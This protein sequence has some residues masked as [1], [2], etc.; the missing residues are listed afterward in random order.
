MGNEGPHLV[1]DWTLDHAFEETLQALDDA[2]LE[3]ADDDVREHLRRRDEARDLAMMVDRE[4][5][6]GARL[7]TRMQHQPSR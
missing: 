1:L 2:N 3:V 5:E 6:L 7:L 4:T